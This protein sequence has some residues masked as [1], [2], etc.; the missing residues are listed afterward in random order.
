MARLLSNG[1]W[2]CTRILL[3]AYRY[4]VLS[5]TEL[6]METETLGWD[7]GDLGLV[8]DSYKLCMGA[9]T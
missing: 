5:V 3:L 9:S 6:V 7:A 4:R 2:V 8:P 1:L